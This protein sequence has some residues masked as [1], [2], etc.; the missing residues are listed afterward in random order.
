MHK[1][2]GGKMRQLWPRRNVV[3]KRNDANERNEKSAVDPTAITWGFR[4][5]DHKCSHHRLDCYARPPSDS[6]TLTIF[7]FP[8]CHIEYVLNMLSSC[9]FLAPIAIYYLVLTSME[10]LQYHSIRHGLVINLF[11]SLHF[12]SLHWN[13]FDN[14]N[15]IRR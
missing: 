15:I 4:S 12:V 3:K 8:S 9:S 2:P 7:S 5:E 1:L 13:L 14:T 10:T 6:I 11:T